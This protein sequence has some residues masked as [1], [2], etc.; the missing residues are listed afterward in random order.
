MRTGGRRPG[1]GMTIPLI[2]LRMEFVVSRTTKKT[3]ATADRPLHVVATTSAGTSDTATRPATAETKIRDAL[4]DNPDATTTKLA[5]AAG[6]GRSTAAKILARW[7]TEGTV[8]RTTG[9]DQRNPATWTIHGT[10]DATENDDDAQDTAS[11]TSDDAHNVPDTDSNPD[12]SGDATSTESTGDDSHTDPASSAATSGDDDTTQ[13]DA[14]SPGTDTETTDAPAETVSTDDGTPTQEA[15]DRDE[16]S[17]AHDTAASGTA[18]SSAQPPAAGTDT[19]QGGGPSTQ[20]QPA[21]ATA[22]DRLPKGGLYELVKNY[23]AEHPDDSFGP[24]KIGTDLNRSGGAVSN[25]LDKLVTDGHAIKTCE[26]PK[27]FR[28]SAGHP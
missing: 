17:P 5:M 8:I 18:H 9:K 4:R 3:T 12:N 27:R 22:K 26:A 1:R 19:D 24:A 7:A 10:T 6:I 14:T 25:A 13:A 15:A 28:I 20:D 21:A 2:F 23:L 16:T 11:A